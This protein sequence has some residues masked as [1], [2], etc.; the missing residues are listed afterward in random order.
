MDK[1]VAP[2]G[3]KDSTNLPVSTFKQLIPLQANALNIKHSDFKNTADGQEDV[4]AFY[5]EKQSSVTVIT[6]CFCGFVGFETFW[7]LILPVLAMPP[8]HQKH[9][10]VSNPVGS[11]LT[12]GQ[13][14]ET[15]QRNGL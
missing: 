7:P 8:N 11:L 10:L 2:T 14:H 5:F 1:I 3:K 12:V 9:V 15:F 4:V 6:F 13:F